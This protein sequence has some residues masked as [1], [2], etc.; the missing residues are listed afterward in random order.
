[1]VFKAELNKKFY[2]VSVVLFGVAAFAWYAIY[3]LNT[4]EI[5]MEDGTPM[6]A[7]SR[8]LFSLLLA[9]VGT[10]WTLSLVTVIRQ[11]FRGYAFYMDEM[12]IH[13]TATGLILFTLILIVPVRCIPYRAIKSVRWEE[14]ILCLSFDKK[15][16]DISPIL[17]PFARREFRFFVGYTKEDQKTIEAAL[18]SFREKDE[19]QE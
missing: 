11:A 3:F 7:D 10:S 6:G 14:G 13:A 16:I 5:L 15:E 4:Q 9:I 12:G 1:M 18:A 8:G 19:A 2:I 17:R